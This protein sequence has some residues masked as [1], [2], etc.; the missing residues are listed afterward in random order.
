MPHVT[1]GLTGLGG[2]YPNVQP[3]PIMQEMQQYPL[4]EQQNAMNQPPQDLPLPR[5]YHL[6]NQQAAV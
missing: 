4:M 6:G 1:G 5:G 3:P 2:N